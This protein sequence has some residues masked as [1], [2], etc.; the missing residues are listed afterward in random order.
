MNKRRKTIYWIVTFGGIVDQAPTQDEA[1]QKLSAY[2]A[3]IDKVI[4]LREA[5]LVLV[6]LRKNAKIVEV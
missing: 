1:Q 6:N 2:L 4:E 5:D 3:K